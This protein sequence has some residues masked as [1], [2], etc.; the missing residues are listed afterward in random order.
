MG[1]FQT[2]SVRAVPAPA[3][4][5][6]EGQWEGEGEKGLWEGREGGEGEGRRKGGATLAVGPRNHLE[7]LAL[8]DLLVKQSSRKEA[9]FPPSAPAQKEASFLTARPSNPATQRG[10][11]AGRYAGNVATPEH[12][13]PAALHCGDPPQRTPVPGYRRRQPPSN[14]GTR[15]PPELPPVPHR[16]QGSGTLHAPWL[17]FPHE[18]AS[19]LRLTGPAPAWACEGREREVGGGRGKGE[20][21][22]WGHPR[23]LVGVAKGLGHQAMDTVTSLWLPLQ[24]RDTVTSGVYTVTR[25]GGCGASWSAARDSS[26]S[27]SEAEFP[28]RGDDP[29][30]PPSSASASASK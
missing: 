3:P 15:V 2:L 1:G 18:G 16:K 24:A 7:T 8:Q 12:Q 14:P 5:K 23:V 25:A 10:T 19:R 27:A 11:G 29:T 4:Q 30:L 21:A 6:E 26:E 9:S 22:S 20:G 28:W 13:G 17:P